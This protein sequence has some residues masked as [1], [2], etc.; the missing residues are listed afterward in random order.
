MISVCSFVWICAAARTVCMCTG[1]PLLEVVSGPDLRSGREAATYAAEL[2][3]I[4]CFLGVADDDAQVGLFTCRH[5]LG[6]PPG[7]AQDRIKFARWQSLK[8]DSTIS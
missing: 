3:R 8:F 1:V 2:R 4:M 6:A 5:V 7:I